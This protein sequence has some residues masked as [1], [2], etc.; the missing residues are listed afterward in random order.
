MSG[1]EFE[2]FIAS[3]YKELGNNVILT[4]ESG[5]QG[6]DVI[7][8]D[9]NNNRVAMQTK[10]YGGSVGNSAVQEVIAGRKFH[11]CSRSIVLTNSYFTKSA[12]SLALSDGQVELIDR[13]G[14]K[15]LIH[16]ALG[17]RN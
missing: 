13:G 15:S 4:P 10:R 16:E 7:V 8:I 5:D 12:V 17:R 3:L 11:E 9:A 1:R 6:V 2:I 14:L